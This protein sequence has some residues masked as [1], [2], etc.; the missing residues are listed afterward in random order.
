MGRLDRQPVKLARKLL[1][2]A[3]ALVMQSVFNFRCHISNGLMSKILR[4]LKIKCMAAWLP[5]FFLVLGMIVVT[6]QASASIVNSRHNLGSSNRQSSGYTIPDNSSTAGNV[7]TTATDEVCV[8]CHTPHG[9]NTA[10]AAPLWNRLSS[11][12]IYKVY[13]SGSMDGTSGLNNNVGSMS[14]ACLSCHDGTQAMDSVINAPGSNNYAFGGATMGASSLW[15]NEALTPNGVG[16]T[17]D[18]RMNGPAGLASGGDL[19]GPGNTG[20]YMLGTDLSNDHPVAIPYCGGHSGVGLAGCKDQGFNAPSGTDSTHAPGF[21]VGSSLIARENMRL[22]PVA[23][24][25]TDPFNSTV[26][27]SSCHDPHNDRKPSFLRRYPGVCSTCH[28]N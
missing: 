22:Y 17:Y 7:F 6:Q 28:N 24:N 11:G 21:Y 18:G 19:G 20:I 26:E 5:A 4:M 16:T 15:S 13:T 8:F 1:K 2:N 27:C 12:S 23:G 25:T 14:L 10:V 9:S 3:S